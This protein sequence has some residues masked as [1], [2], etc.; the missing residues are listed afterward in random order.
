MT[1]GMTSA[2]TKNPDELWRRGLGGVLDFACASHGRAIVC[3]VVLC[4]IAFL[5]GFAR[6]PVVDRDEARFAQASKQMLASSDLIDIRF[7]DDVRYK[8]PAGIYWMQVAAVKGWS[9]LGRKQAEARISS[10][11]VPSL[12]GAIGAVLLTY[13]VGL[14]FVS[15]RAAVL[16]AVMMAACILLGVEA[17][18]AKTDAVLLFTILAAMGAMARV[19]LQRFDGWDGWRRSLLL[20]LIFWGALGLGVLIKGPLI[21]LFI[22]LTALTLCILDRSV[23]WLAGLNPLIGVPVFL[24]VVLPWFIAIYLRSGSS[25]FAQ[26]AGEDMLSKIFAGQEGHGA[27]PGY[28]FVLFF[29][30]FWPASLLAGLASSTVWRARAEA[31]VKFLLAWLV[32]SWILFELV[33]T[34]CCRFIRR[35]RSC[36][37]AA[38]IRIGCRA[39]AGWNT[40]PSG[41][42]ACRRWSRCSAWCCCCATRASSAG[43]PGRSLRPRWCSGCAPGGSMTSTGRSARCCAPA[44]RRSCWRW[45]PSG[46]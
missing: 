27:P 5:P 21:L 11:R 41:G 46:A 37:P 28:Y 20:P 30:T 38:S 40:V 2:L 39:P 17:R 6:M 9:F 25:F 16:A 13:W 31:P 8:K 7:Q 45:G 18:L 42:S 15:R 29:L 10:Y 14:T 1:F 4:L 36:S 26:S 12:F 44:R 43:A 32:P 34:K 3:L 23:R 33:I 24:V 19:Y 22:G 35:S